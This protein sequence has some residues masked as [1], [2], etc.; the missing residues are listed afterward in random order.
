MNNDALSQLNGAGGPMNGAGGAMP[1]VQAGVNG[2]AAGT[3]GPAAGNPGVNGASPMAATNLP[4]VSVMDSKNDIGG[5]VKTIVIVVLSLVVVTFVGL[6][7]WMTVQYNEASTDVN[8]QIKAA[9]DAAVDENTM[10]MEMEFAE[11]EKEPYRDFAGP[12]DY[13]GLSFR[14]PK[15]WSLYVAKDAV[16]GGDYAAYFNPIEVNEVGRNTINALRLTIRDAA[17][18]TVVAEYQKY[19]E[20]KDSNLSV[21]SV[22][23]AGVAANRYTGRIPDSEL[24]GFIVIFKIRDKTAILQ[25]DS[26]QFEADFNRL[27]ETVR[28]NA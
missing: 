4:E 11:R 10:E 20:R 18:D 15:T 8:G 7:I 22:T 3:G 16:N 14:Y 24:E 23:V 28:F 5:L 12:I 6:F 19:M 17:F 21:S 2:G 27:L 25:T 26:V 13:G 1:Q 9:V